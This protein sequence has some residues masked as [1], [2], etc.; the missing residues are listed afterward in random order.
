MDAENNEVGSC[1]FTRNALLLSRTSGCSK[2]ELDA[3]HFQN[4]LRFYKNV[5]KFEK[6]GDQWVLNFSQKNFNQFTTHIKH[7]VSS[8]IFNTLVV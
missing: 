4:I 2:I 7:H 1:T 5:D 6:I 3:A 8:S